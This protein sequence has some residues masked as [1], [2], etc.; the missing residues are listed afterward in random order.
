MADIKILSPDCD[1]DCD[2]DRDDDEKDER[3]ERGKRG[4]RGHRGHRGHRGP[5]GPP[6]S[7]SGGLLKFS[8]VAAVSGGLVPVTSFLADTGVGAGIGVLLTPPRYPVAVSHSLRNLATNVQLT[9]PIPPGGSIVI[10]LLKNGVGTGI[11]T[12]YSAGSTGGIKT[13]TGV[14]SYAIGDTFDLQVTTTNLAEMTVNVSATV[15]V[16]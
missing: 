16:E 2:D 7:A 8:G 9:A 15:G 14:V 11:F 1:D 12:T 13:A 5:E 4:K 6:G 3:G 10:E